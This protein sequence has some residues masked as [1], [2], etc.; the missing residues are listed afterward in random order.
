MR[1]WYHTLDDSL[2]G[3]GPDDGGEDEAD[4]VFK[5]LRLTKGMRVLD[6]PCGSGRVAYHLASR[7]INVVGVDLRPQFIDR[8][9]QR[10]SRSNL[11]GEF[12]TGDLRHISFH[13]EFDGVYNWFSSFG[14]FTEEENAALLLSYARALR[15]GGRLLIEQLNRERILRNFQPERDISGVLYRAHWDRDEQRLCIRRIVQGVEN[16][17]NR[18]SQRLYTSGQM[19]RLLR[20]A[21]LETERMYGSLDD[22]EYRKGSRQM[23]IVASK[24]ANMR[25]Q[26][27]AAKAPRP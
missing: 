7:G 2:W 27:D 16:P 8:A 13:D 25:R 5:A 1:N 11:K 10:F 23:I 14:Y 24:E 15:R 6:A 20:H 26:R 21:G 19:Q 22:P 9:K 17:Q 3:L 12:V 4:F 18:S